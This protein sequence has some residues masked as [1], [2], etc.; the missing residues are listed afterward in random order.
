MSQDA[1]PTNDRPVCRRITGV[2][3]WVLVILLTGQAAASEPLIGRLSVVWGDARPG[4]AGPVEPW[5]FLDDD[6]GGSFR[7]VAD[8]A[9]Q[10]TTGE[11]LPLAGRRVIVAGDWEETLA[12]SPDGA[13]FRFTSIQP[14]EKTGPV[15]LDV[16]GSQPWVSILLKFSDISTEPESLSYFTNMYSTSFPGIDHFWSENSGGLVNLSGSGAFGWYTLPHP[17]SYYI[18]GDPASANLTALFNDGTAVADP[19]VDFRNYVGINLMFN[20]LL[21]CCAWGGSRWA[22]LDGTTR[23]WRVTWEPPWGYQN[24][25]VI[26]HET[27]HGFGLPHSSGEYGETY[28]NDWDVMSNAWVC[29]IPDPTFGCVGQHTILYHKNI[30]GWVPADRKVSIGA[31]GQRT[32]TLERNAQ[33][34]TANLRLIQLPINGS[35]THFLTV[36]ARRRVGYDLQLPGEGVIIHDV[37]TTRG[38]P[39]HVI[40]IDGNGDTGDAGAMWVPGETYT[41]SAGNIT[42]TV[43]VATATGWIVTVRNQPPT[44]PSGDV[45]GDGLVNSADLATLQNVVAGNFTAGAYPCTLPDMGDFDGNHILDSLDCLALA[46]MFSGE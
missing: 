29:T 21:D 12:A 17:R 46:A 18:T 45:N 38:I 10:R 5:L 9:V 35:S 23:S 6:T 36:E 40:D 11:F 15:P 27:G 2:W 16:T 33:P 4:C 37:D 3:W 8:A 20:D 28:D 30:L 13:V 43:N 32:L 24:I 44:S 25:S 1:L 34:S 42:V 41:N 22:T 19:Y 31:G 14:L 7:L 26:A 39:A